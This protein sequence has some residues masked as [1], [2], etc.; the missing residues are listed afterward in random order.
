MKNLKNLYNLCVSNGYVGDMAKFESEYTELVE[1]CSDVLKST[2]VSDLELESVAGGVSSGLKS[3][4]AAVMGVLSLSGSA[5][6][7][8]GAVNLKSSIASARSRIDSWGNSKSNT[9][10]KQVLVTGLGAVAAG[11]LGTLA[12]SVP[13]MAV[14]F[15]LNSSN[16]D[17]SDVARLVYSLNALDSES[18]SF[19]NLTDNERKKLVKSAYSKLGIK[20]DKNT[21]I[22]IESI[23]ATLLAKFNE[24]INKI[25]KNSKSE[26]V[27]SE[28]SN[29]NILRNCLEVKSNVFPANPVKPAVELPPLDPVKPAVVST[30]FDDAAQ[31][32]EI[33]EEKRKNLE[34]QTNTLNDFSKRAKQ[35][36]ENMKAALQDLKPKGVTQNTL[37][38]FQPETFAKLYNKINN[39]IKN[40]RAS[41]RAK[42]E[43]KTGFMDDIKNNIT[44]LEQYVEKSEKNDKIKKEIIAELYSLEVDKNTGSLNKEIREKMME[45]GKLTKLLNKVKK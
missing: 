20:I 32:E 7:M 2:E 22:S 34:E 39:M 10:K 43:I 40:S 36:L 45:M 21:N 5:S 41:I 13:I 30:R 17:L 27:Q 4:I 23:R 42:E 35:A 14:M 18:V 24:M 16:S 8:V 37:K 38:D 12:V 28:L 15:K 26:K 33:S 6:N 31:D 25:D 29:L 44:L 11:A 19:K 1:Q 9:T 3:S